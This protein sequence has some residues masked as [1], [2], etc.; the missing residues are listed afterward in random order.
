MNKRLIF[1]FALLF[2]AIG[3]AENTSHWGYSGDSGPENWGTLN[4][5]FSI[6]ANGKNQSPIDIRESFDAE[7]PEIAFNYKPSPLKALN[8][9]HTFQVNYQGGSFIEIDDQRFQLKQFHFHSPS[10][11]LIG[12]K[13]YPLEMHLVHANEK[14]DL[15]VVAV[16]FEEGKENVFLKAPWQH[17]PETPGDEQT[18]TEQ[19]D[20]SNVLPSN[21]GY[22]RFSGSLTTPPCSEGVRWLVLKHPAHAS[23]EQIAK[24]KEAMHHPNNRPVQSL[25]ARAVL[26]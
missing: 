6:C 3:V 26:R 21:R 2:P 15:A 8:N 23:Q 14:G 25:N 4:S 1:F 24:F 11:N 18:Y 7:L 9:G 10:E 13:A 19:I 20:A 12:G 17:L 22:Y 5:T 16:L